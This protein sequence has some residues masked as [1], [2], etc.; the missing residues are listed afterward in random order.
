MVI[1]GMDWNA[2]GGKSAQPQRL[3]GRRMALD[4]PHLRRPSMDSSD[5]LSTVAPVSSRTA[6]PNEISTSLT[7]HGTTCPRRRPNVSISAGLSGL[8]AKT[9]SVG[10]SGEGNIR[11]LRPIFESKF[12]PQTIFLSEHIDPFR[13]SPGPSNRVAL[14]RSRS[15][16]L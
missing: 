4:Q 6:I 1:A 5:R 11:R 14:T 8:R 7:L 3:L 12:R 10:R 15:I 2:V 9:T 13:M 16:W